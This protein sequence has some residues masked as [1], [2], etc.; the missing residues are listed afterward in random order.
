MKRTG[1]LNL[2]KE[3]N[4]SI[5]LDIIRKKGPI[6]RAEIAKTVKISPTTVTSAVSELIGDLL[7]CEA[8]LGSSNGGRK[9]I[10]VQ[11]NPNNRFLIGIAIDASKITIAELNL[12]AE[13]RLKEV[14]HL[15]KVTDFD[16]SVLIMDKIEK[17]SERCKS[18]DQ[19]LGIS[20]TMQGIVDSVNGVLL[21]N[22]KLK[23]KNLSLKSMIEKR[24]NI[25]TYIDNDTN[26]NLL[27]EKGFGKY[28]HSKNII[29][30]KVGNGVGASILVNDSIF[31]GFHGGAGEFGHTTIDRNGVPCYCGN[32]GCLEG[33]VSWGVIY[34]RILDSIRKGQGTI[35]S[36]IIDGESSKLTPEVLRQAVARDDPLSISIMEALSRDLAI[37]M[38]NLI[39]LFNPE[40]IIL[41]GEF[42]YKNSYLISSVNEHISSHALEVHTN[43]LKVVPSS[44]GS[45][46]E[47]I[48]SAS[49]LLHEL[50][51]FT[52]SGR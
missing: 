40:I 24:F 41:G 6:S 16:L 36:E 30:V 5:V 3:L 42:A 13:V 12:N 29:Y 49:L 51:H 15:S 38:V 45:D 44:F 33:Y 47:V 22:P 39:N 7:V 34:K 4:K 8:G 52:L 28:Q 25:P 32:V 37:G 50:F 1:D 27:A 31:R 48:G 35:I 17:F 10:L 26:G 23:I 2:I 19:C 21:Y 46:F 11:L 18:L 20:I 9:P 14:H 43:G